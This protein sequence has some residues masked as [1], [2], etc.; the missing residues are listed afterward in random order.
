[1]QMWPLLSKDVIDSGCGGNAFR[2]CDSDLELA[3][4]LN[5]KVELVLSGSAA[6]SLSD[7]AKALK[8]KIVLPQADGSN[9][10]VRR[11]QIWCSVVLPPGHQFTAWLGTYYRDFESFRGNHLGGHKV[12]DVLLGASPAVLEGFLRYGGCLHLD[13]VCFFPFSNGRLTNCKA[14]T[15]SYQP[16]RV[17]PMRKHQKVNHKI[18]HI[19]GDDNRMADDASRRWNHTDEELL[20]HFNSTYPQTKS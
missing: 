17:G 3:H 11:W 10:Y 20:T 18:N 16:A 9:R 12:G 13:Y 2:F 5:S 1:M 8:L 7:A 4:H 15:V 6:P 19:S 14:F